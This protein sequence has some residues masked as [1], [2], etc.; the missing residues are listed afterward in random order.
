MVYRQRAVSIVCL[1][2]AGAKSIV[3]A[4]RSRRGDM[5]DILTDKDTVMERLSI[6]SVCP[7]R[8]SVGVDMCKLCGCIIQGK[9]RLAGESCPESKWGKTNDVRT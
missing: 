3:A 1:A 4:S 7:N 9:I 5:K 8:L 6:C 2:S